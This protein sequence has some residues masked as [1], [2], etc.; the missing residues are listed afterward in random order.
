M[1]ILAPD[2]ARVFDKL[3]ADYRREMREKSI[4]APLDL[5]DPAIL[6]LIL[7]FAHQKDL[8]PEKQTLLA[9]ACRKLIPARHPPKL[10]RAW[11]DWQNSA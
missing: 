5:N 10:P 1:T 6:D 8:P 4:D 11:V 3:F 2:E 9:R 7:T